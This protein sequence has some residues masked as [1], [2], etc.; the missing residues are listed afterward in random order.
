[1]PYNASAENS[2]YSSH[3]DDFKNLVMAKEALAEAKAAKEAAQ[4]AADGVAQIMEHL[5]IKHSR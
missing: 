2:F 5:G 3:A 4:K 1:L